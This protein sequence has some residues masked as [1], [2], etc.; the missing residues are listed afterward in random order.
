[1]AAGHQPDLDATANRLGALALVVTD[2]TRAAVDDG[3]GLSETAAAAL[4]AVHHFLGEPSIE[5]LR[6]VLGL[7]HSATV[8][9]VDRLEDQGYVRRRAGPDARTV[10][11]ALTAS[12][13]RVAARLSEA[14]IEVL[15]DLVGQLTAHERSDLDALLGRLLV[16]LMREPGATRWGCRLCDTDACG[17]F[18]GG[19]PIGREAEARYGAGARG[20][21]RG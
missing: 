2:R 18:S 10:A 6:Q 12:G 17:R 1:M 14:R 8:R 5:L 19:C 4:S 13:R 3:V 7:T 20:P 9:L 11:V 16:A 21:A 15:S